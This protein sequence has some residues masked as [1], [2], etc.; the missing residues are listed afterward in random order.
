MAVRFDRGSQ[1]AFLT[2]FSFSVGLTAIPDAG[3]AGGFDQGEQDWD[4]LFQ[5]K[6]VAAEAGV[7]YINPQRNLKSITGVAGPSINV[8]E[9]EA[10]VVPRASVAARFGEHFGCLGSYREPWG[11]HANYGTAWTYIFSAIQQHFTSKDIGVTCSAGMKVG[12]GKLHVL[13]GVSYQ[14]IKYMLT[15]GIGGG[16]LTTNVGDRGVAWRAGVAYEIP[17]YALLASLIYNS[18]VNYRMTGTVK[19]SLAPFGVPVYGNITMPQSIELKF[20][21]GVAPGW[22]AF[23]SVKWTNWNVAGM[24]PICPT[25]V[26]VCTAGFAVSGLA[27]GWQDS[28]TVTIGAV[29]QFTDMISVAGNLTWDQ[30]ASGGFTSQTDTWMAG[31]TAIVMPNENVEIRATGT[32]GIMTGGTLST[33]VLPN[34]LPNPAGYVATFGDDFIYTLGLNGV[35]RF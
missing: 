34:G 32:V 2:A 10:I 29:H 12:M 22:L 13:A 3:L 20:R 11:G 15:Q 16:I 5:Q 33:M 30:G 17:E 1:L 24:S 23:G 6:T 28:W 26:P 8:R 7:R 14:E 4:F 25:A 19:H 9:T 31:L 21:S 35:I 18:A 27:L